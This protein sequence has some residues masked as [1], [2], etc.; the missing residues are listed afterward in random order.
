MADG[1][2]ERYKARLVVKGFKQ[3]FVIDY[4]DTFNP[5]VMA[6]TIHLIL[7]LAISRGWCIRQLDVQNTFL[8]GI[9]E[10]DV[11]MKQP[12][13]Y[14]SNIHLGYVCKLDKT[15][16]V[17]KQTPRA[18]Y[19]HLSSKLVHLGFRPS[20]AD[21]SSFIYRKD[22]V[23]IFLLYVDDIIVASSSTPVVDALLIDL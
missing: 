21:T 16:H 7:S 19:S 6:A 18:W 10:E 2:I 17:L 23:Q 22:K 13:D 5:V 4:D 8:H 1:S 12:P 9:L 3:H 20:K 11:Y 14:Y 15:L